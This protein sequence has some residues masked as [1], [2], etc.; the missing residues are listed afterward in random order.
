MVG[1]IRDAD[2]ATTAI[3]AAMTGHLV[4][5]TIHTNNAPSA[6][7]R[8]LD[9]GIKPYLL[10]GTINLIIAQRLVR[11]LC[12]NCHGK[13]CDVCN[14]TGYKGRTNVAEL[15]VP[16]KEIE[17]LISRGSTVRE[18]EEAAK[19]AGM[20]SM[21]EDGLRKVKEGITSEEEVRRVTRE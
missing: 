13:G 8:L 10:G 15:L 11:K 14:K 12:S 4:L 18:F 6:I 5:T 19:R 2:T 9:M 17:D 1:E 20:I 16:T 21:E 3:N 7:P